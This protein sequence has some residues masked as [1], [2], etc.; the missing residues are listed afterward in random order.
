MN[1]GTLLIYLGLGIVSVYM[2]LAVICLIQST[3]FLI[4]FENKIKGDDWGL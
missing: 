3:V 2:L 4:M 1:I